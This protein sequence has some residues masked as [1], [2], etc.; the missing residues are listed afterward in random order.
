MTTP[1]RIQLPNNKHEHLPENTVFVG[2]GSHWENPYSIEE[3]QKRLDHIAEAFGGSTELNARELAVEAFRCDL[4]YGP[5]SVW[6]WYGPHMGIL[7]AL[8]H[9][10]ELRGKNLACTCAL[11]QPCHADVLLDLANM[12]TT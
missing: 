1:Q 3:M 2:H 9:L 8:R 7:K 12:E 10:P 5:D 11:D 4:Q 6:W